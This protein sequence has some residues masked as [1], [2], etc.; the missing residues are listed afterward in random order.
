MRRGEDSVL[1][2]LDVGY[3]GSSQIDLSFEETGYLSLEFKAKSV[4]LLFSAQSQNGSPLPVKQDKFSKWW[5]RNQYVF[6][7]LHLPL[8]SI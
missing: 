1:G 4:C 7:F 6:T 3:G 2:H 5:K 8:R